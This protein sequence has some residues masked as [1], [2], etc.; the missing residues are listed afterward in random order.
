[1]ARLYDPTGGRVLLDGRDIRSY[2]PEE[3]TQKIGFILQ[4]PFLFTGTIRDNI[5]YGN[6]RY[7]RLR[8]RAHRRAADAR[9]ISTACWPASSRGSR[10]R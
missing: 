2:H 4:E 6:E 9:R 3:R 7:Q 1:M 5:L 10:R 8:Q